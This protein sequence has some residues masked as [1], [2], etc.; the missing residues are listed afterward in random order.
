MEL[1]ERLGAH[2]KDVAQEALAAVAGALRAGP[3]NPGQAMTFVAHAARRLGRL[4]G[5]NPELDACA[6]QLRDAAAAGLQWETVLPVLGRMEG[7]L[8]SLAG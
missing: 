4:Y 8:K 6:R 2:D 1:R 5:V 3:G 7:A